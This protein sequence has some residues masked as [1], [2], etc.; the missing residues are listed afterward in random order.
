MPDSAVQLAA[1]RDHVIS[2]VGM[3]MRMRMRMPAGWALHPHICCMLPSFP[4]WLIRGMACPTRNTNTQQSCYK[5]YF[6]AANLPVGR[7]CELGR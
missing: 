2:V 6:T 4:V 7:R 3:H 1:A 5:C